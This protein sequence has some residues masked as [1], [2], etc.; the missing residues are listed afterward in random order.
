MAYTRKCL[1]AVSDPT[2]LN[3][4]LWL[5]GLKQELPISLSN[6]WMQRFNWNHSRWYRKRS[7]MRGADDRRVL[8][9]PVVWVQV[10]GGTRWHKVAG[11]ALRGT[12]LPTRA[13]CRLPQH[14]PTLKRFSYWLNIVCNFPLHYHSL[15]G[16]L[17]TI[18]A[19]WF[20]PP[21]ISEKQVQVGLSLPASLYFIN[22]PGTWLFSCLLH[23]CAVLLQFC[24]VW[25]EGARASETLQLGARFSLTY[26]WVHTFQQQSVQLFCWEGFREAFKNVLADFVR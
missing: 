26:N 25:H 17:V 11:L 23:F 20:D 16:A 18:L 5:R 8:G 15:K 1:L 22:Y 7:K 10:A 4:E 14:G 9:E 3:F 6:P 21:Q 13:T 2:N 12:C 24:K 19:A